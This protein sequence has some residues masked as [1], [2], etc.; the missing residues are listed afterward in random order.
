MLPSCPNSKCSNQMPVS[1]LLHHH[2]LD[3]VWLLSSKYK[4][5]L[6]FLNSDK[7]SC[8]ST[9][10]P[11]NK[12]S[13]KSQLQSLCRLE[14]HAFLWRVTLNQKEEKRLMCLSPLPKLVLELILGSR[15]YSDRAPN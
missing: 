10:V 4:I 6:F 15:S 9:H 13:L 14:V 3:A 1:Q 5:S 8:S 7:S 12:I 11:Y 2:L